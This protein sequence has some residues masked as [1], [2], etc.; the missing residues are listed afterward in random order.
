MVVVRVSFPIEGLEYVD[1]QQAMLDSVP[2]YEGIDGLIRKYYVSSEDKK[3]GGG[4]Y[5]WESREK[6]EG[7]YNQEWVNRITSAFGRP[8][9]EYLECGIVVDNETHLVTSKN[10]A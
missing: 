3:F 2:K 5:L 1:F 6:A 8:E 7:W 10:A 4:I 9:L